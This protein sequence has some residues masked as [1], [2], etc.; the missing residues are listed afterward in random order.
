MKAFNFA[1][2][3]KT[4][5]GILS[6]STISIQIRPKESQN[7]GGKISALAE[8]FLELSSD[9]DLANEH[10]QTLQTR[11]G[12]RNSLAKSSLIQ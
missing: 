2:T 5:F 8:N 12:T 6:C 3:P 11:D 9:F 4:K 10:L 7:N 1:S